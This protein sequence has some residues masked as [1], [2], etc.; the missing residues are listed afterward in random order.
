MIRSNVVRLGIP[1]LVVA[2]IL[3]AS[4][5][6]LVITRSWYDFDTYWH[7]RVGLDMIEK[8]RITY[9]AIN[10]FQEHLPFT[11]HE[12]GFQFIFAELFKWG[13]W[14][15]V[16]LLT[17]TC[18]SFLVYG[19]YRLVYISQKENG[20][21]DSGLHPLIHILIAAVAILIYCIYFK[22][23]PQ[24]VS[25]PAL[26]WFFIWMRTFQDSKR[27]LSAV[28][29]VVLA[30][31]V[32][33]VHAAV[34][35][36]LLVFWSFSLAESLFGGD[37]KRSHVFVTLFLFAAA[38]CN[39]D[40]LHSVFYIA[41]TPEFSKFISEWDPVNFREFP[42]LAVALFV[43][44]WGLWAS[45]SKTLFRL[46]FG[47]G[48]LFLGVATYKTFLF[49][50]VFVCYEFASAVESIPYV[51]KYK[52]SFLSKRPLMIGLYAIVIAIL[53]LRG[54]TTPYEDNKKAFPADEMDYILK[55][56]QAPKVLA[57]YD[58]SGYVMYRNARVLADG[59]FD[60]FITEASK[61]IRERTSFERALT[62]FQSSDDLLEVIKADQPK[63]L[64]LPAQS[65]TSAARERIL[66]ELGSPVF[67]GSYGHVFLISK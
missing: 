17:V 10:T 47:L 41:S 65:K 16:H 43:Y 48:I 7:L 19:L 12:V 1:G 64:V 29:M 53:L 58:I 4:W 14:S 25:T 24:M 5:K 18:F 27:M 6:W 30:V 37:V 52:N 38:F 26:L 23:R 9:E 39:A 13:G 55:Q 32:S 8:G 67:T 49:L 2:L 21:S 11:P 57:S 36:V 62:A 56:D 35:P 59:R 50:L 22:L 51:G 15:G 34:F 31:F 63:Y 61:G 20:L 46:I 42:L 33:L 40:P 3:G 60:P 66:K 28:M 54:I 45:K 44:V